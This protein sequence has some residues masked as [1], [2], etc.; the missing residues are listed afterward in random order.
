MLITCDFFPILLLCCAPGCIKKLNNCTVGFDP[1][2]FEQIITSGDVSHSLLRNKADELGCSNW[3]LLSGIQSK[4]RKKAFV[5]GSGDEDEE[6]CISAGWNLSSIEEAD[7][8]VA[9]GTFTIN[10]GSGKVVSKKEDEM[11]YWKVMEESLIA[12]AKRK[13]PMVSLRSITWDVCNRLN[14]IS[15]IFFFE[16][17]STY[18][19]MIIHATII[20]SI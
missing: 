3:S 6:Y 8:I 15:N 17:K 14:S 5:F 12:A 2:D 10:D 20:E 18:P 7:L 16:W 9:R 4:S 11:E 13:V 1:A 19:I